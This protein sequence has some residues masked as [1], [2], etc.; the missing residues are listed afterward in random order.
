M[1]LFCVY[2]AVSTKGSCFRN[3]VRYGSYYRKSDGQLIQRYRCLECRRCFSSATLNASYR[4]NKRHLNDPLRKLLCSGVSQRRAAEIL[5][6]SPTT[7]TRKF[8]FL[9]LRALDRLKQMNF[10]YEKCLEIQFDDVETFEHTKCKPL[11][12]CLAVENKTRRILGFEVS[13]MPAKGAL[14][15]IAKK[16]YGIRQDLRACG[17]KKLFKEIKPLIHEKVLITSDENPHYPNDVKQHFPLSTHSRVKGK[18]GC[19]TG[20]GE[21]K[22]VGYDPLFSLN[23]TAAMLRANIN[24]LIRKTWCTTKKA[25]RLTL[26]LALY[27]TYHNNKLIKAKK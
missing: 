5:R 14:S 16:K 11:S 13:P 2:C 26:H 4:Q 27:A 20:Q 1:A 6:L 21:L 7:V 19:I 8:I 23:H 15:K 10:T 18:R 12:I 24:R 9:G 3:F 17:R 25:E 22:K